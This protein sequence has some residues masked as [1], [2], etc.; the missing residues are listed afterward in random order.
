M[1][2]HVAGERLRLESI[3]AG[4]SSPQIVPVEVQGNGGRAR[5]FDTDEHPR[6]GLTLEGIAALKALHPEIDHSTVTAGNSAGL[7]DAAAAVVLMAADYAATNGLTAAGRDPVVGRR[8]ASPRGAPGSLRSTRSRRRWPE[9]GVAHADIDLF[10]INEAFC[11]VPVATTR[12][13]GIDPEI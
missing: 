3:D 7:N 4:P 5:L 1:G 12:A 8:S 9:P 6:R 10:E 13:L 11:S 2:R